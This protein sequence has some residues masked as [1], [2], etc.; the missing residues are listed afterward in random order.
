[1]TD[2]AK[3][4][5]VIASDACTRRHMITGTAVGLWGLTWGVSLAHAEAAAA[6]T[7]G[8]RAITPTKAIHAEEDFAASPG[9]L[10][11]ALLDAKQFSAFSGGR[12]AQIDRQVG[13]AFSLFDGVIVGRNLELVPDQR[14]VQAWRVAAWPAGTWSIARFE[15]SAQGSGTHVVLDHTGFPPPFAEH[16]ESGWGENYWSPLRKYLV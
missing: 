15:L 10:Y 9:R 11:Q 3:P 6:V 16:L 12:A 13:G 7:L 2:R 8:R 5:G 4:C 1:M 14:I